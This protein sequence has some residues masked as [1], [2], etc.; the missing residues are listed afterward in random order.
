MP[1]TAPSFEYV[2]KLVRERSA[3][4][5]E[6][7]KE[8]L[9]E[10]R[11][12]P[13]ARLNGFA[14]IDDLVTELTK[15][16]F[17]STHRQV[18]EALTTNETH[19]YRDIHPFEA[20]KK[21]ILPKLL[22][23]RAGERALTIWCAACSSGQEP[24]SLAMMLREAF[25][26][27]RTWKVSILGTDLSTAM[28][29]RARAGRYNQLEVNRGLPAPLLVKYFTKDGTEWVLAEEI[30]KMVE[31]REM[32]LAERWPVL[33]RMDLVVLRNVLIYFDPKTKQEILGRVRTLLKPDAH[34]LLGSAETTISLDDQFERVQ[35]GGAALYRQVDKPV[36]KVAHANV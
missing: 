18:V 27:L 1:I 21:E 11:L 33:P 12:G 36:R 16:S 19:F 20:L 26:Q 24:Y 2:R 31:Y 9:V 17:N 3:I 25:P 13:V 10:A 6:P 5:L 14:S 23:A 15:Q 30:R 32:N 29:A 34:L 4:V 8:Y 35:I 22:E 7:G 28:L